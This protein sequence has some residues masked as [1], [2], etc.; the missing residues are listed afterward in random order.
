MAPKPSRWSQLD[1]R[2]LVVIGAALVFVVVVIAFLAHH[3]GP[4]GF[5]APAASYSSSL[6]SLEVVNPADVRF[7][8]V[9]RT[10][11]GSS[12][13]PSCTVTIQGS[14]GTYSGYDVFD[15]NV[16]AGGVERWQ[17]EITIPDQGAQWVDLADS[18]IN[19]Q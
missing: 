9:T 7:Q 2:T 10:S 16:P 6:T 14:N 15:V 18:T 3:N 1:Q 5:D 13:A 11:D 12:A 4:K 19:C 8:A 17:G